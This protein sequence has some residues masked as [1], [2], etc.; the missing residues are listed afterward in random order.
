MVNQTFSQLLILSTLIFFVHFYTVLAI[1]NAFT[2]AIRRY[3]CKR[4]LHNIVIYERR[5][6][7]S[8][9]ISGNHPVFPGRLGEFSPRK[10]SRNAHVRIKIRGFLAADRG[11]ELVIKDRL[12][13]NCTWR[14]A[15]ASDSYGRILPDWIDFTKVVKL[16]IVHGLRPSP[17]DVYVR[18]EE[19][20]EEANIIPV[21]CQ[22]TDYF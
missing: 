21:I 9:A 16:D 18:I 3:W 12:L 19:L 4:I 1:C 13:S 10:C 11:G 17:P 5:T 2:R 20:E 14:I 6:L 22:I 8:R 15:D 7:I